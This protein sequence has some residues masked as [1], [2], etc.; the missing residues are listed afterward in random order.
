[1]AGRESVVGRLA[2]VTQG[3]FLRSVRLGESEGNQTVARKER[4]G[5]QGRWSRI[6]LRFI[7]A[8]LASPIGVWV[9]RAIKLVLLESRNF[10]P[11]KEFFVMSFVVRVIE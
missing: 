10:M 9:A 3:D 1:M 7:R 5:L 11:L 4:S 6:A 2:V 8:T